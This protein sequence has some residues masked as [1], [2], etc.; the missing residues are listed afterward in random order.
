[1]QRLLPPRPGATAVPALSPPPPL[2]PPLPLP[3]PLP[4]GRSLLRGTPGLSRHHHP[5]VAHGCLAG[6]VGAGPAAAQDAGEAGACGHAGPPHLPDV[7]RL[8]PDPG[9]LP[10]RVPQAHRPGAFSCACWLCM[11]T[12]PACPRPAWR[13]SAALLCPYHLPSTRP[14][15]AR[16]A[17]PYMNAGVRHGWQDLPDRLRRWLP[18]R[19]HHQEWP[20]L[21]GRAG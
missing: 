2:P 8:C 11:V 9:S 17:C 12:E 21:S 18:W 15:A 4:R 5:C 3:L 20:L 16:H 10:R 1:M 13:C 7:Q 6:Q 19:G 14:I